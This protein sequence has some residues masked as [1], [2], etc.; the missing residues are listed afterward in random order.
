MSHDYLEADTVTLPPPCRVGHDAG[1]TSD[2]LNGLA[3][4]SIEEGYQYIPKTW[5]ASLREAVT[6]KGPSVARRRL[7]IVALP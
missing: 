3:P 5:Q 4:V 6:A 7:L 1:H 2:V